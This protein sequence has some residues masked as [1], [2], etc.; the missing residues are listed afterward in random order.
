MAAIWAWAGDRGAAQSAVRH[1]IGVGCWAIASYLDLLMLVV[2]VVRTIG[3][4]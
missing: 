4:C 2:F 3:H 1:R